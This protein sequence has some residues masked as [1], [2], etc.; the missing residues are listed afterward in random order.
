MRILL[1]SSPSQYYHSTGYF[2]SNMPPLNLAQLA[3]M[4]LGENQVRIMPNQ[5]VQ[6][7]S[8]HIMSYLKK[9]KPDLVGFSNSV[10]ADCFPIIEIAK[11]IKELDPDLP[12]VVGGQFPSFYYKLFLKNGFDFVVR[13]EGEYTFKE[14]VN[15]FNKSSPA[16]SQIDGLAYEQNGEIR[17]N[18]DR[19]FVKDLDT[20]PFPARELLPKCKPIFTSEKGFATAIEMGRGCPFKC[21]FC[22]ITGFWKG[23]FRPKSNERILEELRM[24]RDQFGCV[25]FCVIDDSFG[26]RYSESKSLMKNLLKDFDLKWACQIRTDTVVRHPDLIQ[27]AKKA[28]LCLAL[29]GFESYVQDALDFVSKGTTVDMNI[30]ASEILR[31]NDIIIFGAHIFGHPKQDGTELNKILKFSLK[32]VDLF[33][34]EMYQPFAYSRL[35]RD[36]VKKNRLS[37]ALNNSRFEFNDYVIVDGRN[38]DLI[39][40]Y[41]G[42]IHIKH[43]LNFKAISLA[44]YSRNKLLSK[45]KRRHYLAVFASKLTEIMQKLQRK[46]ENPVDI[47]I[48]YTT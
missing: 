14:L 5:K 39:K 29:I 45:M 47:Q 8:Y 4:V 27:I 31:K 35:H 43:L 11:K 21:N 17:V 41:F 37:Y 1:S 24:I 28:G 33:G 6:L 34:L 23:T 44:L 19:E 25:E 18:K 7:K 10:N 26:I 16:L 38:P 2:F 3:A 32:Y 36:L 40:K 13:G 46:F 30:A 20:L 48:D 12:L 42:L 22:S 9:F 15:H